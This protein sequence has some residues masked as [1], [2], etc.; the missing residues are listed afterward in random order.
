MGVVYVSFKVVICVCC[1][2][3]VCFLLILSLTHSLFL[4]DKYHSQVTTNKRNLNDQFSH[5]K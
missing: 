2:V 4:N 5:E 3:Y 1:I